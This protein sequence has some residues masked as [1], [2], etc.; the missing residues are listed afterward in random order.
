MSPYFL[1]ETAVSLAAMYP[2]DKYVIS[3]AVPLLTVTVVALNNDPLPQLVRQG[4]F[5]RDTAAGMVATAL[6]WFCVRAVT[7]RLDRR[8]PWKTAFYRR[9]LLQTVFGWAIPSVLLLGLCWAL[10]EWVVGQ[11]MF[12]TLFPYY[13]FPFSVLLIAGINGYYL[14]SALLGLPQTTRQI[15]ERT[16]VSD[17]TGALFAYK[18]ADLYPLAPDMI[19]LIQKNDSALEVYTSAGERLRMAGTLDGLEKSLP[20]AVFFRVNRQVIMHIRAVKSFR[21]IENGKIEVNSTL[22]DAL[23][24]VVSQKK[25]AEFRKWVSQTFV[26]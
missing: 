6:V 7:L 23:P 18:G 16:S 4:W 15:P 5:W 13:E 26:N 2:K 14:V 22:D 21:A 17:G 8:M 10:F 9:L 19:R 11:P 20:E 3:V 24:P 1:P 12:D 25:A